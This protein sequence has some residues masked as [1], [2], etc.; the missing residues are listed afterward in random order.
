MSDL[1]QSIQAYQRLRGGAHKDGTL[2]V[3]PLERIEWYLK[4]YFQDKPIR[5]VETGC[6]ASTILFSKYSE[7][8]TVY[9]YDDKAEENSSVKFALE[10]PEFGN[11]RVQWVFG[12]T[13]R[14]VFSHPL[15]QDADLILI[16]GPHGYPFPELEYYAFY[17][18]LRPGG[19]LIIDDIHIP[20][21]YNLYKFLSQDDSFYSHGRTATTAFFQRSNA[22]AFDMEGDEWEFQRYNVQGFPAIGHEDLSV[23]HALPIKFLFDGK[24]EGTPLVRGFSSQNGWP[25]TE[26]SFSVIDI[27]IASETPRRVKLS[28][29]IEPICVEDRLHH[30]PGFKLVV[31]GKPVETVEFSNS[32]RRT[33]EVEAE[34][35][36]SETLH[37]EFWH[38][39]IL[40]VNTL[41][42]WRKSPWVWFDGR[43]LNFWLYSVGVSDPGEPEAKINTLHSVAGSMSS[44]DYDSRRFKFFVEDPDDP[45]QRFHAAGRFYEIDE[46]EVARRLSPSRIAILDIGAGVGNHAVFLSKFLEVEKI[47]VFEPDPR[48]HMLLRLNSELNGAVNVDLSHLTQTVGTDLEMAQALA[49]ETA[50]KDEHFGL[51]RIDIEGDELNILKELEE[52]IRRDRPLLLIKTKVEKSRD[53]LKRIDRL[54]Y[55]VACQTQTSPQFI[56]YLLVSKP[57]A[58]KALDHFQGSVPIH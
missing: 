2:T 45:V 50:L 14:T 28:F 53:F 30:A 3:G 1:I 16:D 31:A 19:I 18:R 24:I 22:P 48:K 43:M 47:V 54:G 6:G 38:N 11:D 26:G 13:Q 58:A 46:L 32:T 17:K 23:G 49:N 56:N 27:K 51:V 9:T 7:R 37:I 5:S 15:E 40:S 42:N 44:F 35:D 55:I 8:H 36:G 52:M 25:V 34:T 21:I 20:T 41:P 10:Y 4:N 39:G 12:P 57:N 29:D 33:I